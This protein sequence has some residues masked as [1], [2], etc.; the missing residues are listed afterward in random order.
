MNNAKKALKIAKL[1]MSLTFDQTEIPFLQFHISS[2]QLV[3]IKTISTSQF[4]EQ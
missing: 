4:H 2:D 1:L 3:R